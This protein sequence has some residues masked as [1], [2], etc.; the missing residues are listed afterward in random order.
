MEECCGGNKC[1][2]N[3]KDFWGWWR[4]KADEDNGIT[5]TLAEVMDLLTEVKEFNAGAI[6]AYL[7]KHVDKALAKKINEK[8]S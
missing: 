1:G 3:K 8:Q 5:F 2:E 6:D 4:N 7:T